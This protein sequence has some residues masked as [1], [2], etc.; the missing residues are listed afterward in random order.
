MIRT[1]SLLSI[2]SGALISLLLWAGQT[3]DGIPEGLATGTLIG[4]VAILSWFWILEILG[5]K[6]RILFLGFAT[7]GKLAL[8]AL[9]FYLLV[10]QH[11]VNVLSFAGGLLLA[12]S[13][14]TFCALREPSAPATGDAP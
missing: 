4:L 3:G 5:G 11:R 1:T 9:A 7:L 8:Y 13:I 10:Y 2:I 14:L 12:V 6:I